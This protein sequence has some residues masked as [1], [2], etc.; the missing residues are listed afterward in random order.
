MD[1][2]ERAQNLEL[3]KLENSIRN[4][5]MEIKSI[6]EAGVA[7]NNKRTFWAKILLIIVIIAFLALIIFG[8]WFYFKS[9]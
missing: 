6:L 2:D 7:C 9:N 1:Q 4:N 8:A 3:V 5:D